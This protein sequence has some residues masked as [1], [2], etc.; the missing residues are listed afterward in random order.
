MTAEAHR[1]G[2]DVAWVSSGPE[3]VVVLDLA[4]PAATPTALE[5]SAAAIWHTIADADGIT[6]DE[7]LRVLAESFAVQAGDIADDVDAV[8]RRLRELSLIS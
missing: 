3:R 2:G 6:R 4:D 8:L 5:G 1:I 7:L